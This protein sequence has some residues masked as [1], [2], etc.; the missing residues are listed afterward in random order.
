[1]TTII[2]NKNAEEK[3]T[4]AVKYIHKMIIIQAIENRRAE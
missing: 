4:L 2:P 3:E 1:M